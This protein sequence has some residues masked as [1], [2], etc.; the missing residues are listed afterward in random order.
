MISV[1]AAPTQAQLDQLKDK[2]RDIVKAREPVV[3]PNGTTVTPVVGNAEQ[4]Q[5]VEARTWNAAQV[6]NAVG[7][8]G[9]K[10]GLD[11]PSMTYQNIEDGD[12]DFVRDDV[13]RW[14][15]PIVEHISKWLLPGGTE[16][17]WDYDSRMR[18]D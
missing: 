12:I 3:L 16:L 10:L 18:S 8:H 2:W 11:G 1:G 6:A 7:I 13:D 9:W 17:V 15:R 5:L 14:A 4:A